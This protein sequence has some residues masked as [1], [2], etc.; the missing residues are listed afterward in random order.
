MIRTSLSR[1][2][3]ALLVVLTVA[4]PL[5]V[6]L[7]LDRGGP[8]LAGL[9]LAL[10]LT[11]RFLAPGS[12]P[13]RTM[14]ALGAGAV[15]VAAIAL[16]N[17][18]TLVLLYPAGVSLVLLGAFGLTLLRPPTMI[19][20]VARAGGTEL[21]PVAIRYTRTVTIVWCG[22]FAVNAVIALATALVGSREVW[23]VYNGFVSYAIV[24]ALL[25]G[26]WLIRP[27]IRRRDA[28]AAGR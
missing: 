19:E 2:L 22:F 12:R 9:V 1:G 8:R 26:E 23:V 3:S 5:L 24:G 4:Y 28:A 20:R 15:L 27:A 18:E 17:V 14:A 10:L 6:Y 25:L 21:G 13:V 16:S 7:V 11:I